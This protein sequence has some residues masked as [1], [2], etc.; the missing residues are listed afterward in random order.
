MKVYFVGSHSIGKTTCARYVSEKYTQPLITE[1]A[2]TILSEQELQVDTLRYDLNTVDDYQRKV[3][4]R[5]IEEESKHISFVS[6][7]SAIDALAYACQHS[8]IFSELM[9]SPALVSYLDGLRASDSI[10]FFVRPIKATLKSDGV[11]E[12]LDWDRIISIDAMIKM[13]LHMYE[14]KYFQINT[15]NMQERAHQINA[16]LSLSK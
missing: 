4:Y 2:R 16:V 7:R 8:R 5:Q 3:F 10:L 13:L 14:I 9:S 6:D 1:V 12:F 15:D 11:R